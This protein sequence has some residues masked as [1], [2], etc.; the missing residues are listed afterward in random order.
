MWLTRLAL[1][2]PI[3]ILMVSLMVIVLGVVSLDRLQ[4]RPL[5]RHH[6]PGHPRRDLLYGRR[7][8][9]H[10]ED[11]HAAHRARRRAVAGRRPRREHRRKQGVSLVSVWFNYGTNLDNAQFEVSQRVAQ[12]LNTLPPG[13]QQPFIL[14][15]DITNIP[16]SQVPCRAP[17]ARR[18]AAL[19]S[20]L[21]RHRAAAR[22]HPR[23]R[24]RHGERRQGRARSRSWPTANALRARSLGILD[25]VN[26]V[27]ARTCCLPSGN[28][29]AGDR[30]YNVFTNTQVG[31]T[32]DRSSDVVVRDGAATPGATGQSGSGA[33]R[34]TWPRSR[35]APP[36]R[37]RSCASTAQ[38]GVYLRV[39]KQPGANTIAVV[40]A[41]RAALP[42]PARRPA[43]REARHLVR[44]VDVHPRRGG[45]ARARGGA[46]RP[47]RD[48]G[49]PG[50]PRQPARDRDRRGR[51]PAVDRR[52]V[53]PAL[54]HRPDA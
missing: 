44:P 17:R 51:H 36:T 14:K 35:T 10:R 31:T 18:E 42:E 23:R 8:R 12:I 5:P 37:R 34:A 25:V 53:H 43:E 28:L 47:A 20:R 39:L 22:A 27:R 11:H 4:R 6:H 3:F 19:R 38:R 9:R 48:P 45:G 54:L 7:A 30:D 33:R 50:L 24:Q 52:D 49:H 1:R 41:V 29:R 15:F 16:S 21:Q 2:N 40:D 26:A 32:R 46:G 13:I